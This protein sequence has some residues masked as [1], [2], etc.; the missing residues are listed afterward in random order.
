[1]KSDLTVKE[2][3]EKYVGRGADTPTYKDVVIVGYQ[4]S[5]NDIIVGSDVSPIS[6]MQTPV[7]QRDCFATSTPNR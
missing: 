4:D 2:F 3:A 5:N 6:E 7:H 1:M